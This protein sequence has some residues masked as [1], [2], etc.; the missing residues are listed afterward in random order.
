MMPAPV[1][2][3]KNPSRAPETKPSDNGQPAPVKSLKNPSRAPETKPSDNGQPATVR[4]LNLNL[5][6]DVY[7]ELLRLSK[8]RRSSMTEIIRLAIGLVKVALVEAKQG[9]KLIVTTADGQPLKELVL[10]N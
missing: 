1:K 8:D 9:H 3:L 4:R 10:T 6:E 2:S 5:W 7:S